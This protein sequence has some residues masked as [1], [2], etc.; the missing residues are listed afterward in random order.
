MTA[1]EKKPEKVASKDRKKEKKDS[2]SAIETRVIKKKK[3]TEKQQKRKSMRGKTDIET[4]TERK[5]DNKGHGNQ[6]KGPWSENILDYFIN[7]KRIQ[8]RDGAEI[9]WNHAANSKNKLKEALQSDAHMI[10]ADVLLRT[11]GKKRPIMAHPPATDS[12]LTLQEW[13][14]GVSSTN[15][16]IKLDFKSIEAVLPSMQILNTLKADIKQ[17]VWINADILPGPGG[18]A[19]PVDPKEFLQT[20]A[21]F[22]PEVTLSLGWTTGWFPNKNNTGYNWEMVRA[23]EDICKELKQPV[24]FPVRAALV[25]QSWTQLSW[26]LQTSDRYSLTIWAGKDDIYPVEDLLYVRDNSEEYRVYYDI[27]DPQNSDLKKAIEHTQNN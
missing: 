16:G 14:N 1:K 12:D 6:S 21:S 19:K 2:D 8:R 10:E 11:S 9:I 3:R 13:L 23:M 18:K 22:F 4:K 20:V 25:H 5:H 26:L 15:K 17:P 24:T 7:Q 27:Y